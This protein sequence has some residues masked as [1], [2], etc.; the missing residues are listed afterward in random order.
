MKDL[1]AWQNQYFMLILNDR[2]RNRTH[3]CQEQFA[4]RVSVLDT[5][6]YSEA[7]YKTLTKN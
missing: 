6:I 7:G 2:A 3:L 4:L 5:F 1:S